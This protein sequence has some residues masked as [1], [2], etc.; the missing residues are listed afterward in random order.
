MLINKKS[1]QTKLIRVRMGVSLVE[2]RMACVGM[3]V[4]WYRVEKFSKMRK[5][6]NKH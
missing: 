2:V 5:N 6:G 4:P 1:Q 3:W